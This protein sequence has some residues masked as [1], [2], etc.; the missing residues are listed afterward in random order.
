[1]N[2]VTIYHNP[3]C[4]K[5]R[6]TLQLLEDKGITPT[7]RKYLEDVPSATELKTVLSQLD[8]TARELLRVKE[9]EYKENGLDDLTLSEDQI[10]DVM[11]QVPKL[12]ERPIV[13]KDGKARI[14]RPPENVLEIL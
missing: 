5:S 2:D 7:V 4:T 12:I 10:I 8:M 9:A 6:Q 3:R 14:G 1:M 13:I 11:T